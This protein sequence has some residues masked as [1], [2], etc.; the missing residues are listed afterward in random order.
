MVF[1]EATLRPLRTAGRSPARSAPPCGGLSCNSPA[2]GSFAHAEAT[3]RFAPEWIFRASLF[4]NGTE[5]PRYGQSGISFCIAATKSPLPG[6]GAASVSAL[7]AG[8]SG[9]RGAAGA[10]ATGTGS[11]P[12]GV[13]TGTRE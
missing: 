9:W 4:Q 13:E 6:A 2:N 12:A 7:V 10:A 11:R 3:G 8:G 5:A 1:I